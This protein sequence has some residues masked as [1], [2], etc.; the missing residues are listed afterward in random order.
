MTEWNFEKN[1]DKQQTSENE[2]FIMSKCIHSTT[3]EV[4]VYFSRTSAETL[5]DKILRVVRNESQTI[6]DE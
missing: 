1:Q 3:Y 2:P 5:V 6:A 4:S